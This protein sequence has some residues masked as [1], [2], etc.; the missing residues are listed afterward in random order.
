MLKPVPIVFLQTH[1]LLPINYFE[2]RRR[3]KKPCSLGKE[4]SRSAHFFKNFVAKTTWKMLK[5]LDFFL[6][7]FARNFSFN[8]F[9]QKTADFTIFFV[10]KI[11]KWEKA[12]ARA[13]TICFIFLGLSTVCFYKGID[14]FKLWRDTKDQIRDVNFAI[15]LL[16]YSASI[17]FVIWN[18]HVRESSRVVFLHI[19]NNGSVNGTACKYWG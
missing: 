11:R 14:G 18:A 1:L 10:E 5:N 9:V 17:V 13:G 16:P 6:A 2:P 12:V 15:M 4:I 19:I 7:R 3:K 8:F